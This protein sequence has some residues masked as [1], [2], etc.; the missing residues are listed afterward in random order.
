MSIRS[1]MIRKAGFEPMSHRPPLAPRY[2]F[3]SAAA[4]LIP[5]VVQVGFPNDPALTDELVWLVT[6]A[7]AFLL[8]LHYGLKGA[9]AAMILGTVLFLVVQAVLALNYTPDDWRITVPTYIAYS[10]LA[11]SVGWLSEVLHQHYGAAVDRERITAISQ[12]A[13]T[14]KHE[15]N[16]ALTVVVTESQMLSASSADLSETQQESV[17]SVLD[18]AQRMTENIERLTR[19]E[20]APVTHW[21]AGISTLDLG[22]PTSS[23]Q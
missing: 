15:L 10:C 18:A 21:A 22:A 9:F 5:V 2:W 16:N 20:V 17:K 8:S 6:L 3:Y 11:I 12:L 19:L 23:A 7:P 14:I 1:R 4:Y 13:M